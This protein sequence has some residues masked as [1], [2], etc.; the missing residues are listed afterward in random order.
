M[1]SHTWARDE[2]LVGDGDEEREE[3]H[4]EQQAAEGGEPRQNGQDQQ[5][6]GDDGEEVEDPRPARARDEVSGQ[7][8]VD[9]RRLDLG[10]GIDRSE[11]R[12]AD[13]AD[14]DRRSPPPSTILSL[15]VPA[16]TFPPTMSLIE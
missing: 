16:G 6:Q 2:E 11:R 1:L 14:P 15:N 3:R 9:D 12:A 5:R 4:D 8:V 7:Q 10:P 13:V